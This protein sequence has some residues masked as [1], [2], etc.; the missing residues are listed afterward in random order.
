MASIMPRL[1]DRTSARQFWRLVKNL[2]IREVRS[3]YQG[4]LLGLLWAVIGPLIML[5][6]Y[7][8]VF[9]VIFKAS[10]PTVEGQPDFGSLGFALTLFTGL[11]IHAFIADVLSAAPKCILS[12]KNYVKKVVF[13]LEVLPLTQS[14][15]A[16]FHFLLKVLILFAFILIAV[17]GLPWTALL[18]PLVLLPL[19]MIVSG[20]AFFVA[21]IGVYLRDINQVM[22]QI[23]TGL[24]F[25]GPILYPTASAPAPLRPILLLNPIGIPVEQFRNVVLFAQPPQWEYLLAYS[26]A[27]L[28]VLVFGYWVFRMLQV[29]FADVM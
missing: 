28:V 1:R 8:F 15:A 9:T 21:A 29:G 16:L 14:G 26:I 4:S 5:A 19:I 22:P 6:L 25:L 27:S 20:V 11:I 24:L 10:W 13:P 12:N 23:V 2:T 3:K 7:T 17:G 18:T